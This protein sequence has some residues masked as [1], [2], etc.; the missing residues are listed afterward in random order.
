LPLTKSLPAILLLSQALPITLPAAPITTAT[1]ARFLG[2]TDS[3][4]PTK[5]ENHDTYDNQGKNTHSDQTI[6]QHV[7]S[8]LN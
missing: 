6:V 2:K 1:A 8:L 4:L 7:L 3:S 5:C